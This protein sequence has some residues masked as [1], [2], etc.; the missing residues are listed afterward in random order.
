VC[1]DW[2]KVTEGSSSSIGVEALNRHI[3]KSEIYDIISK[4]EWYKA[5]GLDKVRSAVLVCLAESD[6]FITRTVEMFQSLFDKEV[7]PESWKEVVVSMLYKKGDVRDPGNYRGISL[8]SIV[9]KVYEK[10]LTN[11]M[12][13]FLEN[14]KC[15][16]ESAQGSRK[17]RSA[18]DNMVIFMIV[19]QLRSVKGLIT[20]IMFLD[21]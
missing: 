7:V 11:R 13:E 16:D 5:A 14:N 3:G 18:V 1:K 17:N 6:E 9:A 12:T 10:V 15:Y 4:L 21:E 8:M 19:L 2:T 20:I